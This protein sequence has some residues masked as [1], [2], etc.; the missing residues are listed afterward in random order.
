MVKEGLLELLPGRGAIVTRPTLTDALEY[1]EVVTSLETLTIG[2]ACERATDQHLDEINALH[3]EM[4]KCNKK[5]DI[6]SYYEANNAVH[7]AIVAASCNAAL[8]SVH[9]NV[10]RHITRLQNLSEALEATTD[11]S[12]DEHEEFIKALME[13][14]AEKA[15][16]ALKSHLMSTIEKMKKEFLTAITHNPDFLT[17]HCVQ[18]SLKPDGTS[19][20]PST[21]CDPFS[22]LQNL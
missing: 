5:H 14:D 8:I 3:I 13:R 16:S 1:S 19:T 4:Q 15:T 7:R 22:K 2:L 6:K 11:E 17:T 20:F 10:Q 9:E 12:F 21:R 18:A